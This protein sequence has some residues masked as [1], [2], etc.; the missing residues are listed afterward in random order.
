MRFL[1]LA[2]L[3]VMVSCGQN[4]SSTSSDKDELSNEEYVTDIREVDLLDV[5]MDVPVEVRGNK[6]IFK[7]S[8]NNSENGIRSSCAVGVTSGE[9]YDFSLNGNGLSIRTP[10]GE[11]MNF[12]RISG[13][14]GIVGGWSSKVY[15]GEQLI[16][17]RLTFVSE[18]RMVMR[19][20]CE[21]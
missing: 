7:S 6:I 10:Q 20:H 1:F 9:A 16:M 2:F 12:V 19:T 21:G 15:K 4:M 18:N 17:R 5:A 13:Q 14:S 3:F 8:A 11:K